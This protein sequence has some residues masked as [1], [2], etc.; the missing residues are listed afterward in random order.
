MYIFKL[1]LTSVKRIQKIMVNIKSNSTS[2]QNVR[3]SAD[4]GT[5]FPPSMLVLQ[6]ITSYDV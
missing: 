3:L 1:F 6:D 5:G 4:I 2:K